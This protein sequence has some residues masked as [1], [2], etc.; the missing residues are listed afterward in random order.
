MLRSRQGR[1]SVEAAPARGSAAP[2]TS[3]LPKLIGR[4]PASK[5]AAQTLLR[6]RGFHDPARVFSAIRR[7]HED[8]IQRRNLAKIFNRLIRACEKSADPD[9]ALVSFERLVAAL[10]NPNIFYHYLEESPDRLDLL[11]KVFAHSQALA[12]TLTR[13]AEH[14]HFLIAPQTLAKPREK[15]WLAAE[16][17][18]LLL[19]IRVPVQKY[20]AIRRFRRRETLR[21][22]ARDLTGRAPVEETTL[23]LS[24][25]ADVCLQAVFEV[26]WEKV[27]A[28]LKIKSKNEPPRPPTA[29]TA[30]PARASAPAGG[31]TVIGMGK[32][33]GQELN[34][35]S[36]VDVIFVYGEEGQLTPSLTNHQFYTKLA[37]EII[38]AVGAASAEG[39]IFRIDLRL[40]PEGASGPLVRSVDS[41]ENYYAEFG[42]TWERMALIKARAVAGDEKLGAEFIDMVQPFVYAR[43][44]GANVIQQ[45]AAL[46]KRIEDEVVHEDRL[47]RH[48]KLG[49]GG[50]REIEF[51]VQA[52]QV[53]RGARM[54]QLRERNTLR[55]LVSLAKTKTLTEREAATL[56]D[57]YRFLRNVEHRLQMEMELQTHTIP[58]EKRALHRLACSLGFATVEEFLAAQETQTAAVRK[59]YE[60]V[61]AGAGG[62]LAETAETLL[63]ADKLPEVLAHVGFADA[64]AAVKVVENLW[65]GPG[66]GHVSQRTKELFVQVFPA[67][68]NCAREVADP[69]GALVRFDK[70]VSAYGSR[71]LLYELFANNPKLVE[72][73]MRLG[74][75]SK[76]LS[77]ALAR[78]PEL[79]DEIG[80]GAA[81]G[82]PKTLER[83]CEELRAVPA[84]EREPM[85]VVR[86]WKQAEMVR[87]GIE[88]VMGLVDIEQTHTEITALAEACLRYALEETQE[89]LALNKLPFA[90]IGMG[91]FGGRELGYGADLDVLFVGG[92]GA[93]DQ[94]QASKL[95]SSVID[96]MGRQTSAGA[97]FS[98]DARLRPDG[99]KGTLASSLE[100]HREY[101]LKRAQLW[102]RQALIKA[103]YVAG[104]AKLGK[105]FVDMVRG[106]VYGQALTPEQLKEIRDMRHRI[107]TERGDQKRVDLE[108][109]TGPGGLVDVEFLVQALQLRHGHERA[110]LRT[111]HTLA[112]LNRLTAL[113]LIEEEPSVELRAHYVLLRRIESTL[114]RVENTSVSKLPLDE[115]EQVRLAKRL[116]FP[117][118]AAFLGTYRHATR[119]TRELYEQLLAGP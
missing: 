97:L 80:W 8:E 100:A 35:S 5:P 77:D 88:D 17:T 87:I 12:D 37:E 113:G 43:H 82:E 40:R 18:R 99:A 102:E 111:V 104:D 92:T 96:F 52:F 53:L 64:P 57:A 78:Q 58:D 71:G 49:I 117:D 116:G 15:A 94:A 83:M 9:R 38:R 27:C 16:L 1:R 6:D 3:L 98:V 95:A 42:E 2:K 110:Q 105:E 62:G 13:N 115:R 7:L 101:Y 70:F 63:A 103:R 46:K 61:L 34:Y 85:E 23:E 26:A 112:A 33:G 79:F 41:C 25:L 22:G 45:M 24:N 48:V 65:H 76:Y 11:V 31:F 30:G 47:T 86:R 67:L 118:V 108:F 10:P 21:I 106:I 81:L 54:A 28:D 84:E 91:K 36:D 66:F 107:E 109:K 32:L 20:D 90:V 69:D 74:D 93:N 14:F 59:I 44:A 60:S 4:R 51:I 19:P 39:N 68:L 89:Q 73:L 72:M 75:A 114:R 119:R 56:A 50:I 55:A 29:K